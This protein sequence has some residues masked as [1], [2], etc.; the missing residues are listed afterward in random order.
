MPSYRDN[1][2]TVRQAVLARLEAGLGLSGLRSGEADGLPCQKTI[3]NWMRADPAFAEAVA[4]ARAKGEARRRRLNFDPQVAAE[5]VRRRAE[6]EAMAAILAGPGMPSLRTVGFWRA[7]QG[8]F[9]EALWRVGRER[10]AEGLARARAA[11][12]AAFDP[13]VAERLYVRLWTGRERLRAVLAS[14]PAFPSWRG[15]QR[16]RRENPEFDARLRMVLGARRRRA[17]K[18][19]CLCTEAMAAAIADAVRQGRSL[20]RLSRQPGMPSASAMRNWMRERPAFAQAV[21]Q[22][23]AERRAKRRRRAWAGLPPFLR[24]PRPPA[25]RRPRRW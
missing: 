25:P 23:R 1:S 2:Y 4:A 21:R 17:R 19:R 20:R 22:A 12:R 3:N 8:P 18:A 13:A 7:T 16:W 24:P 11:Q 15:L 5:I 14:D 9:A 6:G 10:R